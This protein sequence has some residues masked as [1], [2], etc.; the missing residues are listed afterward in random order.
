MRATQSQ[1]EKNPQMKN[2]SHQ[3]AYAVIKLT[4]LTDAMNL[5]ESLYL[6]TT[7]WPRV[8]RCALIVSSRNIKLTNAQTKLI[9]KSL[10]VR[11]IITVCYTMN[12][13]HL[14]H[15]QVRTHKLSPCE[16]RGTPCRIWQPPTPS[17]P[18]REWFI[19]KLS[20]SKYKVKKGWPRSKCLL[21][22][23]TAAQTP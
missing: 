21:F 13:Q 18:M 11:D 14:S 7:R 1:R 6:S 9:A 3:P 2:Q 16:L 17:Q 20:R 19:S 22:W 8:S 4:H 5:K 10:T 12:V 23:M 15:R